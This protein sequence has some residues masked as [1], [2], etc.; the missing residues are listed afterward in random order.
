MLERRSQ[1]RVFRARSSTLWI[2]DQAD[3]R[4][5]CLFEPNILIYVAYLSLWLYIYS[6]VNCTVLRL[7]VSAET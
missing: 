6:T 2:V 1:G 4:D 3:L 7:S 5:T